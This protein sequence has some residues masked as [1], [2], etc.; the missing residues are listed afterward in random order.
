MQG[1]GEA[2]HE[3]LGRVIDRH[4]RAGLKRG[5]GGDVEDAARA[6]LDHGGQHG[7][8]ERHQRAAVDVDDA[9]LRL[10]VQFRDRPAQAIAGVVDQRVDG[11]PGG[12]DVGHQPGHGGGVGEVGG[13]DV[14]GD[15]V[16]PAQLGRE[17]VEPVGAARGEDQVVARRGERPGE[18]FAQTRGRAGDE[19]SGHVLFS[20]AAGMSV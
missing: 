15:V 20:L 13:E 19:G 6:A 17:R 1:F 3:R 7:A 11:Q 8:G 10:L 5:G 4:P 16:M 18:R 2:E 12:G 14:D 9:E